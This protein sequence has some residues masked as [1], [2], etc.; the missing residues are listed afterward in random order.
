[1]IW[2]RRMHLNGLLLFRPPINDEAN[3]Y[4]CQKRAETF[5]KR[6]SKCKKELYQLLCK[7][8]SKRSCEVQPL[9]SRSVGWQ[10]EHQRSD[11]AHRDEFFFLAAFELIDFIWLFLFQD[12]RKKHGCIVGIHQYMCFNRLK[13][14][15]LPILFNF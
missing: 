13:Q 15:L 14:K 9:P 8:V 5:H 1:M 12:A 3:I 4:W 7:F 6:A 10:F 11:H 2:Q